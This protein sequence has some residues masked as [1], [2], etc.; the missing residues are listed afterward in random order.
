MAFSQL[1]GRFMRNFYHD[2]EQIFSTNAEI[3]MVLIAVAI[4]LS[5]TFNGE[6]EALVAISSLIVIDFVTGTYAAIKN[7]SWSSR[8]SIGGASKFFRYLVY[9]FVARAVDKVTPLHV[10]APMMDTYLAVTEAGSI[11]E[12]FEKLGYPVP[13]MIINKL[14]SLRDKK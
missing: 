12:N 6:Y 2:I 1:Q 9:M 8:T 7:G 13:T 5:W 14:K 11:L 4:P 10:F 3:K